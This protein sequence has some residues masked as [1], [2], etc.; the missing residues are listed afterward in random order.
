MNQKEK[1]M[2]TE[3]FLLAVDFFVKL[4]EQIGEGDMIRH[5][6]TILSLLAEMV[7]NCK[8]RGGSVKQ[9]F[10]DEDLLSMIILSFHADEIKNVLIFRHRKEEF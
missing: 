9:L 1:T 4:K 5:R 6:D 10:N 8:E 3:E 7:A 2:S